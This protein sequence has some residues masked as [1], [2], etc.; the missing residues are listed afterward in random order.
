MQ[1]DYNSHF[2]E[3]ESFDLIDCSRY[4]RVLQPNELS[5]EETDGPLYRTH[6]AIKCSVRMTEFNWKWIDLKSNKNNGT[7]EIYVCE[8]C[9]SATETVI[10]ER[11]ILR[12]DNMSRMYNVQQQHTKNESKNKLKSN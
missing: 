12:F 8:L 1:I 5:G 4:E 2:G 7:N 9:H 3:R 10:Y 11:D 6:V